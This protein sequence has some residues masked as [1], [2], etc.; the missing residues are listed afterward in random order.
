VTAPPL[1]RRAADADWPAI[2]P[3]FAAVVAGGD[4]YTYAPDT[5][6]PEARRLWMG[7]GLATYVA[8]SDGEIVGTYVLRA[9][10]PGL[11]AHVANAG[12]MVRPGR[13]GRGI[14]WA[15]G[16][17]SLAEAR[18]AGFLAMQFNAVVSTNTRAVAL[19]QR[20]GF[21]IVGTI[22]AGFCHR[23]LGYVDLYVM[24]RAL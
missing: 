12:Y 7:P 18:L 20:L 4:T 9:N 22:P 10:Q 1:V 5:P 6:E 3:I 16:E 2:W 17:H 11:G 14:G 13:S 19:W 8:E 23:E 21:M 15:M 24:Y